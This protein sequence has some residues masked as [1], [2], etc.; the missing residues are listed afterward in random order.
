ALLFDIGAH[1]NQYAPAGRAAAFAI[2]AR[3]QFK[4]GNLQEAKKAAEIGL[5]SFTLPVALQLEATLS[6]CYAEIL[7]AL[8]LKEETKEALSKA[9]E[10]ILERASR[11]SDLKKREQFLKDV[12]EHARILALSEEWEK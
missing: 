4:R 8:G 1:P 5:Q 2:L 7:R 11:L 12:P 6:L 9:K 10:R 3:V